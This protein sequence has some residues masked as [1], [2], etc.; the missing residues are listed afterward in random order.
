MAQ[1]LLDTKMERKPVY[2]TGASSGGTMAIKLP[3][4]LYVMAKSAGALSLDAASDLAESYNGSA[5]GVAREIAAASLNATTGEGGDRANATAAKLYW[6][7]AGLI[8][9]ALPA[10]RQQQQQQQKL[11]AAAPNS[12]SS[13][14]QDASSTVAGVPGAMRES[15]LC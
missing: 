7:A 11:A 9:G 6:Q 14:E 12:S 2:L 5:A 3:G 15:A 13:S 10:C 1:F 8:N 4:T